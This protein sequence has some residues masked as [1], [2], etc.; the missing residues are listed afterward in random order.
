MNLPMSACTRAN[1][2]EACMKNSDSNPPTRCGSNCD[3]PSQQRWPLSR[4]LVSAVAEVFKHTV[5]AAHGEGDDRHGGG[6]VGAVREDTGVREVE[7]RDVVSLTPLVGD[8]ALGIVAHA[9]DAGFM[10]AG[11]RAV[12]FRAR[13]PELG[14]H[15]FE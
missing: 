14:A 4:A 2:D 3:N 13:A 12:G 9:A 5:P 7:I 15:G 8:K 6:F 10:Q 11:S 1:K